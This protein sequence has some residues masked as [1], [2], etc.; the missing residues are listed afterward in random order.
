MVKL[1]LVTDSYTGE[2]NVVL[3][4]AKYR[5]RSYRHWQLKALILAVHSRIS[6]IIIAQNTQE[7][8]F[9]EKSRNINHVVSGSFLDGNLISFCPGC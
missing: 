8:V 2:I 7:S 4:T 9:W 6:R 3:N 5:N 1:A